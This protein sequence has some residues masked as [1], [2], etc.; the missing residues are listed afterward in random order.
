MLDGGV[1]FGP[2]VR[3]GYAEVLQ[4]GPSTR[5][6]WL[7]GQNLLV[8]L[9]RKPLGSPAGLVTNVAPVALQQPFE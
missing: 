1:L 7:A 9:G 4:R 8:H 2:P 3:I 5:Q 6:P